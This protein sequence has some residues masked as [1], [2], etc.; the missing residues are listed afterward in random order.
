[1]YLDLFL[2]VRVLELG[3]YF[4]KYFSLF[5]LNIWLRFYEYITDMSDYFLNICVKINLFVVNKMKL[6]LSILML[7]YCFNTLLFLNDYPPCH[8]YT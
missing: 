4:P 3:K 8:P 1:M 5:S 2:T 6:S 7:N